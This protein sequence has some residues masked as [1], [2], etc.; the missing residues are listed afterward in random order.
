MYVQLNASIVVKDEDRNYETRIKSMSLQ[1]LDD[2]FRS[3]AISAYA[4][5]ALRGNLCLFVSGL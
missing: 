3:G 1:Q 4:L 5:D 2:M